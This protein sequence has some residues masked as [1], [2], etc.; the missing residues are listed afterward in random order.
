MAKR[1]FFLLSAAC[2]VFSSSVASLG[3]QAGGPGKAALALAE[4]IRWLGQGGLA[5]PAGDKLVFV[6]PLGLSADEKQKADLILITHEH[7][8]HFSKADMALAAK[9]GTLVA[10]PF[11]IK[12]PAFPLTR[13]IKV[14]ETAVLAG[15]TVT[16]VPAYNIVKGANHPKSKG[17]V[18][19]LIR[20]G[21]VTVYV[22]G[23]TERIPEMKAI[24]CDVAFLPLGRV[25]T[26][27]GPAEAAQAAIDVK[28]R[29][30]IPYHFG[31]YEG[32]A[33]DAEEF[34]R[35]LEGRVTVIIKSWKK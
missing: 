34:A 21:D 3:A 10:A 4:S 20:S 18:G 29:I 15:V 22:A 28:A 14:G 12:D 25:Y 1:D 8:D 30:A 2:A 13:V 19:Y 9:A 31:M 7:S 33:A 5:I 27:S 24:D 32:N 23:D 17:W 6:D 26:M 16:A 35:L 11:A